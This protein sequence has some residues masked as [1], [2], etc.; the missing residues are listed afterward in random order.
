MQTARN[1]TE[2]PAKETGTATSPSEHPAPPNPLMRTKT[3]KFRLVAEIAVIGLRHCALCPEDRADFYE[4]L[5][6]ILSPPAAEAA[7]YA[8]TCIRETQW[9]QR[10]L[11]A[12][13]EA[14]KGAA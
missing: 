4:G 8:A 11:L 14:W 1:H 9:A 12:A 7:R 6:T 2:S 3:Q 13:L 5:S 10:E